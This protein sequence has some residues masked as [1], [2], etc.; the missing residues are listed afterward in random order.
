M[1]TV[2][3]GNVFLLFFCNPPRTTGIFSIFC[4]FFNLL[5]WNKPYYANFIG[6]YSSISTLFGDVRSIFIT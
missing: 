4:E 3:L 2:F 6:H 5:F 1:D